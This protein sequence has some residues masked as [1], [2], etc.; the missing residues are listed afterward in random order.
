MSRKKSNEVRALLFWAGWCDG[1]TKMK[2]KFYDE[3]KEYNLRYELIDVDD[4]SG[5]NLSIK[6]GVR[7]VPTIVFLK[8]NKI[9]GCEKGNNS[10]LS[11][12]KYVR[13]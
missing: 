6:F 3:A 9:L 4:E 12:G 11:I 5:T 10:Y 13:K 7:N 8:G 2:P 1:C